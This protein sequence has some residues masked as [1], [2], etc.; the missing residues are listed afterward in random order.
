MVR[1]RSPVMGITTASVAAMY[2]TSSGTFSTGPLRCSS[3][4]IEPAPTPA[5]RTAKKAPIMNTSPW[6][7]LISSMIP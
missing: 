2:S 3:P 7:K 1:F 6:A 5:N 4:G